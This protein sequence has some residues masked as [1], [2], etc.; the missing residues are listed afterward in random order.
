MFISRSEI[1]ELRGKVANAISVGAL[2]LKLKEKQ[3]RHSIVLSN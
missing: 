3:F 2:K 1:S